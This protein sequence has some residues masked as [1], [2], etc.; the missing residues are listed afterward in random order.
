[1]RVVCTGLLG[2][3]TL[4]LLI[5]EGRCER[6]NCAMLHFL[7]RGLSCRQASLWIQQVLSSECLIEEYQVFGRA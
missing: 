3:L 5:L 7:L 4:A 6:G 2:E 1:M